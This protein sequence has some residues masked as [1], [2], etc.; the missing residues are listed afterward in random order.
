MSTSLWLLKTIFPFILISD[1]CLELVSTCILCHV[2]PYGYA[3]SSI[4]F[5]PLPLLNI[6]QV[7]QP[8]GTPRGFPA[9]L[10]VSGDLNPPHREILDINILPLPLSL[11]LS[12][13]LPINT[14]NN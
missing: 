3:D 5:L 1:I 10:G 2:G 13:S 8:P 4:S 9:L 11:S 12:V 14:M 7:K 6:L